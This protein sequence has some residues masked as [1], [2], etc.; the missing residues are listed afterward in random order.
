MPHYRSSY[1]TLV[2]VALEAHSAFA[3]FQHMSAWSQS[4]DELELPFFAIATP[5]ERKERSTHGS[6]TRNTVLALVFKVRGGDDLEDTLDDLSFIAEQVT[7]LALETDE[8]DCRLTDTGIDLD[9]SSG[10]RV[11][12]LSLQFT[13]TIWPSEPIVE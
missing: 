4:V 10:N 8:R 6:S 1:R 9:G 12:T 7:E 3:E 11:G 13:I 5:R 2:K